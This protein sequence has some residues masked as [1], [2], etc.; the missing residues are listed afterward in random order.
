MHIVAHPSTPANAD[1]TPQT[2]TS[3]AASLPTWPIQP[4]SG[5]CAAAASAHRAAHAAAP[6]PSA[7]STAPQTLT[8]AL[9]PTSSASTAVRATST[10]VAGRQPQ[11]FQRSV[12]RSDAVAG[13]KRAAGASA[14][15][16]AAANRND[17]DAQPSGVKAAASRM[18]GAVCAASTLARPLRCAVRN[19]GVQVRRLSERRRA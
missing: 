16:A 17:D 8:K 4:S 1:P 6:L 7:P 10:F 11:T 2:Y 12:A 13:S 5:P 14:V 19:A 9:A 18:G 3:A 15:A